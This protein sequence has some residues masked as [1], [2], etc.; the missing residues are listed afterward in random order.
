MFHR[1][2]LFSAFFL[3]LL[4]TATCLPAD[5][6]NLVPRMPFSHHGVHIGE[7]A[8]RDLPGHLEESTTGTAEQIGLAKANTDGV[9]RFKHALARAQARGHH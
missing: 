1:L 4:S 7:M 6:T 9:S 2:V 3:V 5:T 8:R